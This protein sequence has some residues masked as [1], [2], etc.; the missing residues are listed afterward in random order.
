MAGVVANAAPWILRRVVR[1][2]GD[3]P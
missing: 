1:F 3:V 2:A